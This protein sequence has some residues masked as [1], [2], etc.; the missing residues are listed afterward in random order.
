MTT[1]QAIRTAQKYLTLLGL[2]LA[3]LA[4]WLA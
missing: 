1:R 3:L 2:P 4:W